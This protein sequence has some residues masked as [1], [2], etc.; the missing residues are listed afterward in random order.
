MGS[1]VDYLDSMLIPLSLLLML[2][3]HAYLW[4]HLNLN[5][6]HTTIGIHSLRRKK[7]LLQLQGGDD[8]KGM[9]A[10]QSLRNTL[11][12]T[13]FTGT[14]TILMTLALAA[15]AN[16]AYNSSARLLTSPIFGSQSGRMMGLKYGSASVFL[17]GSFLCTSVSTGMLIDSNFLVLNSWD[18]MGAR[19]MHMPTVQMLERGYGMAVAANRMLCLAFAT[20]LWLL[21]PVPVVFASLALVW[22]LYHLDFPVPANHTISN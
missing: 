2:G 7:W 14:V 21:G 5:P 8:K 19:E 16:N 10:I 6:R 3:Y 12:T 20:S 22:G 13:I 15:L 9:L 11:M 4:H 17:L 18:W 1:A